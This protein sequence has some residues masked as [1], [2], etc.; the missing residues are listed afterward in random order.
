MSQKRNQVLYGCSI[1]TTSPAFGHPS[2][3]FERPLHPILGKGHL[4]KFRTGSQAPAVAPLQKF[5]LVAL[6]VRFALERRGRIPPSKGISD[7]DEV[8]HPARVSFSQN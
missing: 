3:A 2:A 1:L 5:T 6:S 8:S 4:P 7:T